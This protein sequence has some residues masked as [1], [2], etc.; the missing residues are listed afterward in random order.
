MTE[1]SSEW[2]INSES[3]LGESAKTQIEKDSTVV[4]LVLDAS[5]SLKDA[6]MTSIREAAKEFIETLYEGSR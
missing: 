2:Q 3:R 6:D 5:N 1:G 4:Y